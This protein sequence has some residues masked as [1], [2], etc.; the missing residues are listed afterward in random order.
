[1]IAERY[2]QEAWIH[3]YTDGSATD[4]MANG[5]P[6]ILVHF[7]SV[8][9]ARKVSPLENTALT[10]VLKQPY[11]R[12][13]PCQRLQRLLPACSLPLRCLLNP[14]SLLEQQT[15]FPQ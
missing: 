8:Q 10:T 4:A 11:C 7:P 14:G 15:P 12:P 1:M 5:G 13:P 3:A 9:T 2:P 6:G